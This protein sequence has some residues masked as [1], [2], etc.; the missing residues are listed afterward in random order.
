[1]A[2]PTS[3]ADEHVINGIV[4][5]LLSN[6]VVEEAGSPLKPEKPKP[7]KP[8][9]EKPKPENPRNSDIHNDDEKKDDDALGH[10]TDDTLGPV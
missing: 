10:Y 4:K 6:P 5:S 2:S 1:M 3:G 9:L 8:K 7:E